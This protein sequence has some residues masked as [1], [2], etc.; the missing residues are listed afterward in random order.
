MRALSWVKP[1]TAKLALEL[2]SQ[3]DLVPPGKKLEQVQRT[4]QGLRTEQVQRTEQVL[5]TEP[6]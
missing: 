4:E 3:A 5:R 1:E 6:C 2:A